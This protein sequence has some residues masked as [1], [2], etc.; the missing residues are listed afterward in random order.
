MI[1]Y[2]FILGLYKL[3]RVIPNTFCHNNNPKLFKSQKM[4]CAKLRV[5]NVWCFILKMSTK[6]I[7]KLFFRN[8]RRFF[9]RNHKTYPLFQNKRVSVA[10]SM[11]NNNFH[12]HSKISCA[13]LITWI[14][15]FN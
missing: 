1:I 8:R 15:N 10:E 13:P 4:I 6:F 2:N 5:Y 9:I 7:I 12:I 14:Y 3:Y 11:L